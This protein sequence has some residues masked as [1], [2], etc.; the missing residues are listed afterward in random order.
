MGGFCNGVGR[1]LCVLVHLFAAWLFLAR[2]PT[3]FAFGFVQLYLN[4]WYCAPRVLLLGS[5]TEEEVSRRVDDG[6]GVVSFGFLALM[7]VVFAEML[8]CDAFVMTYSGHFLY[9]GAI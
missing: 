8:A 9:D 4:A 5:T 3:Q 6:W 2:V 7:P 1:C